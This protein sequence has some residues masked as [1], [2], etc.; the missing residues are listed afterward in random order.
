MDKKIAGK[1]AGLV[2]IV[3]L[4]ITVL[5]QVTHNGGIPWVVL[6]IKT[7]IFVRNAVCGYLAGLLVVMIYKIGINVIIFFGKE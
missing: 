1:Y 4:I 6:N 2:G 5:C 3:T 7:P